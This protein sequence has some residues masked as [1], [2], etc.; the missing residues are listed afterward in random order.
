MRDPKI[1]A[2]LSGML[3]VAGLLG[4]CGGGGG[5]AG[6]SVFG[7]AGNGGGGGASPSEPVD[8]VLPPSESLAQQCA[9]NNALAEPAR[10]TGSLDTEKRWL[11]SYMD[12]AYLWRE[13]VP[14]VN[15]AEPRFSGPE[16]YPALEAY[17]DALLTPQLT[18]TGA[19]RDR[20]SFTMPS[21]Q[22][23][24]LSQ[25]GETLGYG[26]EW[27]L[28]NASGQRRIRIAQVSADGQAARAGLR[29]GD[30]L[31]SVDGASS[32]ANDSA[33]VATLNAALFP[34]S[35]GS[36]HSFQFRRLDGSELRLSLSAAS[37]SVDPVPLSRVLT[38]AGG[39]RVGY[40]LFNA[41]V[42]TAE[43]PLIAAL[44]DFRQQGI[45]DLVLDLRYNGGGYLFLASELAYMIA[46]PSATAGQLFEQLHYN[47]RRSSDT[48]GAAAQTPFYDKS[49]LLGS[50]GCTLEQPLPALGLRRV[51][52]LS[53]SS[54][55]SASESIINGLRGIGIEVIL[56]GGSTCGKPYGFS[57]KDNC[58]ISY[59]PIEFVGTNAKGFGDYADG[60]VPGGAG[61][62]GVPG[63]AVADDFGR[64]LGDPQEGQLAAALAHRIE[65]RC[66]PSLQLARPLAAQRR[67]VGL[68]ALQRPL[69]RSS[70]I[71]EPAR[72][73]ASGS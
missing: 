9:P 7:D 60:F 48:N 41:H 23:E 70:R 58:G 18:A 49:C 63:C 67:D 26:L 53:Q 65:G 13:Q 21:A 54:T 57:A 38:Q 30:E 43:A 8:A 2:R 1:Q 15:A 39:Q 59:F 44:Q 5:P 35:A 61:A 51:Y 50:K 37:V 10:R 27:S 4:A 71:L 42:A 72:A 56:I 31:L 64:E 11:R 14:R 55:C 6:R 40:L 25:G 34:S 28:Q 45:S 68:D 24:Q 3:V 62:S 16:V 22:W 69:V 47:D 29:R 20:F 46:G 52:V 12:E 17:F 19:R 33:S 32:S 66:S 36:S 73:R